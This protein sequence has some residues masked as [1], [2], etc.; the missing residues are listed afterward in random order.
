MLESTGNEGFDWWWNEVGSG[1]NPEDNEE[2]Y[3]H[4][5]RVAFEAWSKAEVEPSKPKNKE[6]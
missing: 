4:A 1:M 3:E 2:A 5:K 6:Q